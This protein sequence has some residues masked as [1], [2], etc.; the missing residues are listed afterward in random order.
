MCG[1]VTS[2]Q[3]LFES[4]SIK[5]RQT[6]QKQ[7]HRRVNHYSIRKIYNETKM[8]ENVKSLQA[9]KGLSDLID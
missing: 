6:L 9:D 1:V 3:M 2:S 4:I 8:K 7:L 5:L